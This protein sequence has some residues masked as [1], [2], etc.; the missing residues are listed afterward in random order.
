MNR[1]DIDNHHVVARYLADQLSDEELRAFE[2]RLITDPDIVKEVEIAARLK[3]GL[4]TLSK[5]GELASLL[6]PK[7]WFRDTRYL[8]M[9]ASIAVVALGITLWIGRGGFE[10]SRLV[11]SLTILVDRAGKQLPIANSYAILR[12]RGI[13]Y[14]AEIELPATPQAIELRVLPEVDAHPAKYRVAMARIADDDS[15]SSVGTLNDLTPAEDGFVTL[16]FDSSKLSR[17]RYQLTIGGDTD[18]D[19]AAQLSTFRIK[20]TIPASPVVNLPPTP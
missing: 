15:L 10:Q 4:D 8:A 19:A 17:G 5:T 1:S 9:A 3:V 14:D 6:K 12:T 13:S 16:Y 2:E 18:T 11:A 7:A 20:L